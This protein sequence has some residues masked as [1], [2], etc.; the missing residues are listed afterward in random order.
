MTPCSE[1]K[2]EY[3][4]KIHAELLQAESEASESLHNLAE[5]FGWSLVQAAAEDDIHQAR[6]L[7]PK[8]SDRHGV[9]QRRKRVRRTRSLR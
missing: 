3:D 6:L 1:I 7:R 2:K 8:D 9:D 5:E 4:A